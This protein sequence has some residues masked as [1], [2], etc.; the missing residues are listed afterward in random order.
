MTAMEKSYQNI[1]EKNLKKDISK[2]DL[3]QTPSE[4]DV[5]GGKSFDYYKLISLNEGIPLV[6]IVVPTYN[7]GKYIPQTVD[8]IKGQTID[9]SL[10]EVLFVDDCSKDNTLEVI[11]SEIKDIPNAN[12]IK[13]N[14]NG[15]A[16][17]AKNYGIR[18]SRGK[19]I[20]LVDGD[21]F[22]EPHAVESTLEFMTRN[23]NLKY[24]YSQHRKVNAQG[25]PLYVRKGFDFSRNLL[26]NFNFV[27]AVECFDRD[28][29][30][31]I[32]GYRNFYVED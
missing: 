6:S 24:S 19:Y 28:L 11:H 29:F 14:E 23:P 20:M 8:S 13:T 22:L 3:L 17:F 32:G 5:L 31:K 2:K 1:Q 7:L 18:S 12:S 30:E 9:S 10:Y 27:G 15:G 4:Y 16:W 25:D 26:L 21:D